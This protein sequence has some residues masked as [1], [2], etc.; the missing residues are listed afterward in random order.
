M[1]LQLNRGFSCTLGCAECEEIA[2]HVLL[3]LCKMDSWDAW[4][5]KKKYE[6]VSYGHEFWNHSHWVGVESV[7]CSFDKYIEYHAT[8]INRFRVNH[9]F[10]EAMMFSGEC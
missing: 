6:I 2:R 8:V 3:D 4:L 10:I 9:E 5:D 7:L 1:M